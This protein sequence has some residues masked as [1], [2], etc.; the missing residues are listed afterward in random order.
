MHKTYRREVV[1]YRPAAAPQDQGLKETHMDFN[2]LTIKSGEAVAG[3]QELARR[4]GN[5]ELTPTT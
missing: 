3:A 5:P 4:L 2:R 1:L